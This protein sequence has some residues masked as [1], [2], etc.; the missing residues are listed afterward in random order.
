MP[1]WAQA[2]RETAIRAVSS[3]VLDLFM[4]NLFW[5]AP[6]WKEKE[7]KKHPQTAFGC[8][9]REEINCSGGCGFQVEDGMADDQLGL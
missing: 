6:A 5:K 3:R 7:S 2:A 1:V 8:P 9:C 4:E